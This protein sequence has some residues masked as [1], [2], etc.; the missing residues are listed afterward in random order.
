MVIQPHAGSLTGMPGGWG[1]VLPSPLKF[2]FFKFPLGKGLQPLR[3]NLK[4]LQLSGKLRL[5]LVL[6]SP[7]PSWG[8][9]GGGGVHSY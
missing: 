6:F 3:L 7:R 1:A 5:K 9:S 2:F 4:A 8:S